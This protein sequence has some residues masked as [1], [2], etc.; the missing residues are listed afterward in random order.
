MKRTLVVALLSLS[1]G[2]SVPAYAQWGAINNA[3]KAKNALDKAQKAKQALDAATK[4]KQAVDAAKQI[5][6]GVKVIQNGSKVIQNGSKVINHGP[7]LGNIRPVHPVQ[8]QRPLPEVLHKAVDWQGEHRSWSQ[9]GGYHGYRIRQDWFG[10]H[11]GPNVPLRI[12][13][14]AA[15]IHPCFEAGGYSFLLVDPIPPVFADNW[16]ATDDVTVNEDAGDGGYYLEDAAYPN[17]TSPFLL[18]LSASNYP[19]AQFGIGVGIHRNVADDGS[20]V[21]EQ[22][23]TEQAEEQP[24]Q[25]EPVAPQI[26]LDLT[27]TPWT[28]QMTFETGGSFLVGKLTKTIGRGGP[29]YV[30]FYAGG[31]LAVGNKSGAWSTADNAVNFTIAAHGCVGTGA[32]F[33]GA[34]SADGTII[35]GTWSE[36][37]P[38]L[39]G[40]GSGAG[41][42]QI[43]RVSAS[44]TPAPDPEPVK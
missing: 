16:Y 4:A 40:C 42:F 29:I 38:A 7:S 15:G 23:C 26:D 37:S 6:N 32:V 9:R 1:I 33:I 21:V 10:A 20:E 14:I 22:P 28:G 2:A 18:S 11:Y 8:V 25:E 31:V 39:F 43:Q 30:R 13:L 3:M 41:S 17:G 35:S 24:Q 12:N 34:L 27:T 5:Q 19:C 36:Q 44:V